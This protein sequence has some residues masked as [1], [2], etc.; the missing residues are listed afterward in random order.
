[1][2]YCDP[3]HGKFMACTIIY[4]GDIVPKDIS[5]SIGTLKCRKTINFVDWSPTG[6]RCGIDYQESVVAPGSGLA[7]TMRSCSMLSNSSSIKEVFARLNH[8]FD[9]MYTK[10]A[11]VHWYIAEG[12]EEQSFSLAR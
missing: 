1:M 6:F 5:A 10:R 11:F 2:A 4:K 8:K 3:I 7:K 12:M 9:L